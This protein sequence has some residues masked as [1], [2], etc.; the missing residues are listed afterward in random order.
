MAPHAPALHV[1]RT[2][3][4]VPP[5]PREHGAWFIL[6]GSVLLGPALTGRFGAAHLALLL[7]AYAALIGRSAVRGPRVLDRAWAAFLLGFAVILNVAIFFSAPSPLLFGAGAAALVLAVAQVA[8]ERWRLQRSLVA[9]LLGIA[10]LT[11]LG[12]ASLALSGLTVE[13]TTMGIVAANMLFFLTSVPYVRV[14]VFGP[15][16]PQVWRDLRFG[17][18]AMSVLGT[19][20]MA[21][22][23][24]PLGALPFGVELARA[25]RLAWAPP[26]APRSLTILGFTEVGATLFYL[27]ALAGIAR[28]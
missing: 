5:L 23:V 6:A 11:A 3:S 20:V 12:P 17:P 22:S 2:R 7:G 8:L 24:G 13:P 16:R 9:E 28:W 15:G 1:P 21:V 10:L 25:L 26:R 4:W 19:L 14:R 27:V 18:A